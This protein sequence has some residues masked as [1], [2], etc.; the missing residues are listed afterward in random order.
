MPDAL[1]ALWE[2]AVVPSGLVLEPRSLRPGEVK[3]RPAVLRLRR[4]GPRREPR[5]LILERLV[6]NSLIPAPAAE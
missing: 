1:C 2:V 5:P 6:L 4:A 3:Y